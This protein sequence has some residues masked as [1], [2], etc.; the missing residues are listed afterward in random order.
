MYMNCKNSK[1]FHSALAF[2][3]YMLGAWFSLGEREKKLRFEFINLIHINQ[4]IVLLGLIC[5]PL[6]TFS[7]CW[8]FVWCTAIKRFL[9]TLDAHMVHTPASFQSPHTLVCLYY[10][11][12]DSTNLFIFCL[13]IVCT[14]LLKKRSFLFSPFLFLVFFAPLLRWS[15]VAYTPQNLFVRTMS[16]TRKFKG[17][18]ECFML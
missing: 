16:F 1:G 6:Q 15:R 7:L 14:N 8:V 18:E 4:V 3:V 2:A 5:S 13:T 10:H 17:I 12:T 11:A 9:Q